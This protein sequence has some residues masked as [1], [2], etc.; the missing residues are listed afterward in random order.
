MRHPSEERGSVLLL[1]LGLV[2]VVVMLIAVL[3]DVALLRQARQELLAQ[4]DA[5]ALA[6]VQAI[7]V[8][9]ILEEGYFEDGT[10]LVVPVHAGRAEQAVRQH[11]V[12]AGASGRFRSLQVRD[13]R[14]HAGEVTVDLRATVRPPFMAV[15]GRLLGASGDVPVLAGARA[16]TQVS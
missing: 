3:A 16:R 6:G 1:T 13:V 14:V 5:A 15:I 7:D 11:L 2:V 12:A 10:R 4:A 8:D 9:R